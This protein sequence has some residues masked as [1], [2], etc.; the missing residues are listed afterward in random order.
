MKIKEKQFE[1]ELEAF[2]VDT[3]TAAQFFY[4]FQIISYRSTKDKAIYNLLTQNLMFWN[5][6]MGA[7]RDAMFIT[8]GRVF[9]TDNRTHNINRLLEIAED[10]SHLFNKS[11]ARWA[12]RENKKFDIYEPQPQDWQRLCE[13]VRKWKS[14]YRQN[15][16][17]V[18][19]RVVAHH[20]H[21]NIKKKT[22]LF[23]NTLYT[24]L[25]KLFAFL[26]AF[27][28]ALYKLYFEGKKPIIRFRRYSLLKMDAKRKMNQSNPTVDEMATLDTWNFLERYLKKA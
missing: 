27:Y 14:V 15:Y 3:E 6:I 5:T 16:K 21:I 22:S 9:D 10:N 24:E 13:H 25:E 17:P 12:N 18:R 2:R 4:V 26:D 8:L 20:D 19:D 23:D 11:S 7:L 1:E 28:M